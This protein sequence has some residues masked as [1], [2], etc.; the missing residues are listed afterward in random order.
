MRLNKFNSIAPYYDQLA[1]LIFGSSIRNA[2]TYYLKQVPA[3][4]KVLVL[5]GGTGW[6]LKQLKR[7]SPHSKIWF[8]EASSEMLNRV[9]E[10]SCDGLV[11]IHGTE[12]DIPSIQFD[13]VITYFF[14]DMFDEI[15]MRRVID[16]IK[17]SLKENG[18]WLISDFVNHS[19]W[20]RTLLFLMYNFFW[21]LG[22]VS[23]RKLIDWGKILMDLK[24]ECI[25][26]QYFFGK[27][28]TS[29]IYQKSIS[30]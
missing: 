22:A 18:I 28:I 21:L 13:V 3:G 16:R 9:D 14:L 23:V 17:D 2:Q 10:N 26:Q 8:I 25:H 12:E 15:N 20:H 5:G 6:W 30:S 4:A 11:C 29:R 1:S 27:F 7:D 19:F 24:F